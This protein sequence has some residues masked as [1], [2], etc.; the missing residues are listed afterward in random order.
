MTLHE[1]RIP[2]VAGQ[3]YPGSA[4]AVEMEVRSC[5][6]DASPPEDLG[7]VVGGVVPH[8]GWTFSGPTAAKVFRAIK[9]NVNP[10]TFVLLGAVHSWSVRRAAAFPAGAWKTPIGKTAVDG[11]LLE[12]I[13][14][15]SGGLIDICADAHQ[16]EH[17]IEVQVPFIQ[18]L[19]PHA[20]IVPIAVPPGSDNLSVG[21]AIAAGIRTLGVKAVVVGTSDLTHYGLGYGAEGHGRMSDAMG[22][23][24]DN[25]QRMIGL[26][27][28][29]SAA[30]IVP[31]AEANQN[32]C[33]AGAIAATLAAA[34][35][36]G[37]TSARVLEYTTSADVLRERDPVRA[38]GYVGMV[39]E[40][41][42]AQAS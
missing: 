37:A 33:G 28:S 39:F 29:L 32:A 8:A 14:D 36:L 41:G 42:Q 17:S 13:V 10:D 34:L 22:W 19:C 5:L 16:G 30:K 11:E 38:V 7:A 1:E 12:A 4:A 23:M 6:T 20:R 27:E 40:S 3:F 2:G 24:R 31:E 35:S 15:A 21:E 18:T 26:I 9:E 25:D